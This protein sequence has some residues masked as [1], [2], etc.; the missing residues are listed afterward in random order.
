[1]IDL[2]KDHPW[3][4]FLFLFSLFVFTRSLS[5]HG[6]EYRDDEIF[7]YQ[8]TNEMLREGNLLSPTYFGE[9]RFQKPILFY[10]FVLFSYKIF[11]VNWFAARLTAAF[12]AA[13]SICV[14]YLLAR[15]FFSRQVSILSSF[16]LMSLPLFLRHAKNVVPDMALSFFILTAIYYGICYVQ[17]RQKKILLYL[18][19]VMGALGLM[20]KGLAALVVPMGAL[21]IFLLAT[22]KARLKD[23][24]F[25]KGL[26][27]WLVIILPWF[28][29]MIALHGRGYFE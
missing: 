26:G 25:H 17:D 8:S 15:R 27:I 18:F 2:H 5:I 12:F 7:Y 24:K 10:W 3:I 4:T 9:N 1:M 13:L 14:T 11:G 29:F 20:V 21:I 22:K 16:I 28:I 23:L 19:Y 6:V